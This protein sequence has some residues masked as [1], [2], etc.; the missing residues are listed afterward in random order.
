MQPSDPKAAPPQNR[1]RLLLMLLGVVAV[2]ALIYTTWPAAEPKSP[3]SNQGRDAR[4]PQ[5]TGAAGSLEVRLGE[6]TQP[7]VGS[8]ET[9]R[10]PF[11]FYVKPPPPPPPTPVKPTVTPP[12]LPTP[13]SM[14]P[15]APNYV[16][17]PITIKFIGVLEKDGLKWAIFSDGRGQPQYAKEGQTVLGQYK[18]LKIGVESVTMSYLDGRGVQTIPMRGGE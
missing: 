5:P 3:P 14:N 11:K 15:S 1:T 10:N 16:P 8:A 2:G 12:P 4:K 13:Q 18:L 6:L 17:P 7:P 9:T